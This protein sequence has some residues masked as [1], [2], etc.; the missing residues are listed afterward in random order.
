MTFKEYIKRLDTILY[1][2]EWD[3]EN[4]ITDSTIISLKE[5]CKTV[6]EYQEG[7]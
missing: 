4:G 7:T 6:K 2:I 1:N 3:I 5:F